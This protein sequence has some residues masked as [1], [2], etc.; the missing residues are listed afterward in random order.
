M[1]FIIW[2]RCQSEQTQA[3]VRRARAPSARTL[4]AE[5]TVADL[6]VALTWIAISAA[7]VRGLTALAR[8]AASSDPDPD[9]A[10]AA[11]EGPARR[12]AALRGASGETFDA[13][14]S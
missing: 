14:G 10:I 7:S 5:A 1:D 11:R 2:V 6:G 3:T 12:Y 13:V 9:T 8:A 4:R